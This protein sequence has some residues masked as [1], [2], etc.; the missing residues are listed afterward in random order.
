MKNIYSVP[1][2]TVFGKKSIEV[3]N[4]DIMDFDEE[5]DVL[6]VSAS[7]RAY[8]PTSRSLIESL[9]EEGISVQ[10]LS[11]SPL[12]DL[13]NLCNVWLSQRINRNSKG[14]KHIGCVEFEYYYDSENQWVINDYKLLYSLKSYFSMLSIAQSYDLDM[15]TIALPFIGTGNQNGDASSIIAPVVYECKMFLKTNPKVKRIVFIERS[16]RKAEYIASYLRN[17]S[18]LWKKDRKLAETQVFI[19]YS[20]KD[21]EIAQKLH[22]ELTQKG[23][24]TWFAPN[25]VKEQYPEEIMAG[26]AESDYFAIILS[27]NSMSSRQVQTEL[28]TAFEDSEMKIKP[29]FI[30][31]TT[32]P[33]GFDYFLKIW[34]HKNAF[35]PPI[36]KHIADF[37]D[38]L[39][40]EVASAISE[41]Q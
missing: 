18:L 9:Q 2:D 17:I 16:P 35:D 37:V 22:S 1:I 40:E 32:P 23:I 36:D 34:Q 41:D 8:M 39:I 14:I 3:Y 24:K 33:S 31:N 5:I 38:D 15:K 11:S 27:K 29:I 20:S 28:Q 10:A 4:C 26:L 21:E 13:R 12:I 6:T 7:H 25:K 30:E 19:S